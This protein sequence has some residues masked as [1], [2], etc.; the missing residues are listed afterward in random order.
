[1]INLNISPIYHDLINNHF[2]LFV[3][4]IDFVRTC[5]ELN[6]SEVLSNARSK[7][8]KTVNNISF[9]SFLENNDREVLAI[10]L[11]DLYAN[12]PIE[13]S[14]LL[15][16][17]VI[18]FLEWTNNY[19]LFDKIIKDLDSLGLP[20]EQNLIFK[21]AF[22]KYDQNILLKINILK[23]NLIGR[24]TNGPYSDREYENIR[25]DLLSRPEIKQFLPEFVL[26]YP[27]I[28]QFWQF[29]KNHLGKYQ[30][31]RNFINSSF[32]E[33][34]ALL[35]STNQKIANSIVIDETYVLKTWNKALDRMS[36][37][38]EGAITSARTLIESVCKYILDEEK[39]PYKD[40]EDLH[41]LYKLTATALNMAP[42]QHTEQ[43]FK[44]ILSGCMSIVY[45]LGSIRNKI[46]DAHAIG[47]KRVKPKIR[48]AFL[49]V[50]ISGSVCQFI[51]KSYNE[52]SNN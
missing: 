32:S 48:H 44:Q 6:L 4:S 47:P 52:K 29:I 11:N 22:E 42:D 1:M 13:F 36:T 5:N 21:K 33:I 31:R 40:S 7:A 17:I 43:I 8:S 41:Q 46:S 16:S 50:N 12:N 3:D 51:L 10:F 9:L 15:A 30:E 26:N 2:L 38:P 45:G 18:R 34:I 25:K 20:K 23:D 19:V 24:A 14:S 28:D 27:T 37:D 49:A 39:I 35:T